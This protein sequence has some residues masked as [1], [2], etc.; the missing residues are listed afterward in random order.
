MYGPQSFWMLGHLTGSSPKTP[1][2]RWILV[3]I[4]RV[5]GQNTIS[6]IQT[7]HLVPPSKAYLITP[8]TN[9]DWGLRAMSA[10]S[11][12]DSLLSLWSNQP[13]VPITMS[14]WRPAS[15]SLGWSVGG[16]TLQVT[17]LGVD[18]PRAFA[19]PEIVDPLIHIFF[20][21]KMIVLPVSSTKCLNI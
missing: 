9:C 12:C 18:R 10:F 1:A 5:L 8:W 15:E 4:P 11:C 6:F 7:L 20:L 14:S 19:N 3:D 13:G 17:P 2:V 21:P 16:I